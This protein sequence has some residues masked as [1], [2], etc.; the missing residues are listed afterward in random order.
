MTTMGS[1]ARSASPRDGAEGRDVPH[2]IRAGKPRRWSWAWLAPIAAVVV[3]GVLFV[4]AGRERGPTIEVR[5]NDGQGVKPGDALH[6]RGVQV[7]QVRGVTLAEDLSAVVLSIELLRGAQGLAREGARFWIVRP[8]VS[9]TRVSGLETLLG[10]RYVA[11][12][13]GSGPPAR[14]F[15]GLER[16]PPERGPEGGRVLVLRAGHRGSVVA[17]SAVTYRGMK[18]GAVRSVEMSRDARHIEVVVVIEPAYAHLPRTNSRFWDAGG[19]GVDFGLMSGLTMQARSL[20]AMLAGGVAFATPT[21]PGDVVADGHGFALDAKPE[22]AWLDWQPDLT[23][24]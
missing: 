12:E 15:V 6:Y 1:D 20:E 22:S 2:A 19:I 21:R 14:E 17:G 7:G 3:A 4:Q 5:F 18:V 13:P 24:P 23:P 8:E 9:V 16:A 11:A 10:P